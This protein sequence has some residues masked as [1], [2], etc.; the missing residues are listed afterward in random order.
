MDFRFFPLGRLI[1]LS[2]VANLWASL[3]L[4]DLNYDHSWPLFPHSHAYAR[5]KLCL[6]MMAKELA[7][8]HRGQIRV[9]SVHPGN[10]TV[11]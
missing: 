11:V 10:S 8:R 9:A 7:E 6:A 4:S 1:V 2:S 5:S 3:D